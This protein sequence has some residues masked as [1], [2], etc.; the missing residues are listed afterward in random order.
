MMF[1]EEPTKRE[2]LI[3]VILLSA[4][5]IGFLMTMFLFITKW[6]QWTSQ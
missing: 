5:V 3:G 1:E 4:T 6:H 2:K